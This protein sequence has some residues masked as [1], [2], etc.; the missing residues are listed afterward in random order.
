MESLLTGVTAI[1][2]QLDHSLI[3]KV[4]EYTKCAMPAEGGFSSKTKRGLIKTIESQLEEMG[5]KEGDEEC[6]CMYL[7]G[8]LS[9]ME[10]IRGASRGTSNT[11]PDQ[12]H[13]FSPKHQE[14]SSAYE[15]HLNDRLSSLSH[16]PTEEVRNSTPHHTH[17]PEVML[18]RDLRSWDR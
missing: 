14:A 10:E 5:E 1:L 18:R 2:Y 3:I 9:Y 17:V 11:A 13:L 12:S 4:C 15:R 6:V 8:L 7:K 16:H